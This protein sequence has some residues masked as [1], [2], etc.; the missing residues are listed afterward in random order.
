TQALTTADFLASQG[1]TVEFFC[2]E[3]T[4]GY[5]IDNIDSNIRW[6]L[7]QRLFRERVKI[8][9]NSVVKEIKGSDVT[10]ANTLTG[11]ERVVSGID[12]VVYC[13]GDRE[14][15]A[16]YLALKGKVDDLRI[17]GDAAGPRKLVQATADG[18]RVGR[19]I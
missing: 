10:V 8:N 9:T 15:N 12:T 13:C 6:P 5:R 17:I 18:A 16:L 7:F 19:E 1:K 11:E 3:F 2:D 4:P 14:N